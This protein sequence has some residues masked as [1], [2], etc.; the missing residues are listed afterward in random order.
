MEKKKSAEYLQSLKRSIVQNVNIKDIFTDEELTLFL[1][2]VSSLED[3]RL[4]E[5][6]RGSN[7][8]STDSRKKN[9]LK[10]NRLI[11]DR[12]YFI[13]NV[14]KICSE[15]LKGNNLEYLSKGVNW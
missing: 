5:E 12:S 10:I 9:S 1:D 13:L 11:C 3:N 14:L 4:L 7:T 6:K 15:K 2:E 8:N